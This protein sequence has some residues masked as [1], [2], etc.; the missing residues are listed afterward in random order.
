MFLVTHLCVFALSKVFVLNVFV[1]FQAGETLFAESK[2]RKGDHHVLSP[3][4][5][6]VS[7]GAFSL[8]INQSLTKN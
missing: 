4:P 1:L 8:C 2:Q 5:L 3:R 7:R 6:T